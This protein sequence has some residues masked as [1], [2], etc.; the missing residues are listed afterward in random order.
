M[1]YNLTEVVTYALTPLFSR[2]GTFEI[3]ISQLLQHVFD[4]LR[5]SLALVP[6]GAL[7]G[8]LLPLNV[9]FLLV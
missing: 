2:F 3:F 6:E 9:L 7:C 4:F 1:G 8:S 5:F